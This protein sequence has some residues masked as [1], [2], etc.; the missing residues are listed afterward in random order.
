MTQGYMGHDMT[1]KETTHDTTCTETTPG[2][3]AKKQLRDMLDM[4][5]NNSRISNMAPP[6]II[7]MLGDESTHTH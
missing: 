7:P 1:C 5:R 3:A 2:H 4:H 6:Y